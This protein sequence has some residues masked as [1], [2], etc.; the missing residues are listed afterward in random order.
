MVQH[1]QVETNPAFIKYLLYT[2]S[3]LENFHMLY[4]ES[5]LD[6][7]GEVYIMS[8]LLMKKL[9]LAYVK[10]L[11]LLVRDGNRL[12]WLKNSFFSLQL[13]ILHL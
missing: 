1:Y 11:V 7:A 8:I 10:L 12:V 2:F 3:Q 6:S 5:S 13:Q 9:R 4:D